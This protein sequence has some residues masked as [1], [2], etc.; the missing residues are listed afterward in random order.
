MLFP[1]LRGAM[2]KTNVE[3]L[4]DNR[5]ETRDVIKP[6]EDID[7]PPDVL[8]GLPGTMNWQQKPRSAGNNFFQI[9][10]RRREANYRVNSAVAH[11]CRQERNIAAVAMSDQTYSVEVRGFFVDASG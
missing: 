7:D 4:G 5:P 8:S 1:R 2:H 10:M 11:P 3:T 6:R 9:E